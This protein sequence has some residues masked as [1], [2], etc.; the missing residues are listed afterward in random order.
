MIEKY[1]DMIRNPS[2]EARGYTRWWWYGCA[3]TPEGIERQLEIIREAGMGGVE[4]QILY[5]INR[6]DREKGI[7]NI[8][9]FSP[10]FFEILQFT[11]DKC[12][13]LGL[14]MDLT[15]GSSWPFGGPVIPEELAMQCAIPYQ[16]DVHGPCKYQQDLTTRI[17]GDVSAAAMG[18]MEKASMLSETVVNITDR[19]VPKYLFCWPWGTQ[20]EP[21]T[22]PEGDWKLVFF[23]IH[24]YRQMVGKPAP[25]A[26]G[27][28]M[29][30]CSREAADCFFSNMGQPIVDRLGRGSIQSFFCDS[31]ECDGHNWSGVLLKEFRERRGYDL[32]P[33]IYALWGSMGEV[34]PYIRYDYFLTMSELTLE[35][36]FDYFTRWCGQNGSMSRTQAHGTWGDILKAYASAD[37]PEGE[38][39]GEHD[40]LECNTI[41]RRLASSA[42]HLY[43]K[44]IISCE[45]FTWLK[46]PR[47]MET[48]EQMKAAVDAVFLDGM[49]MI[50][51]H[52]FPYSPGDGS[53]GWPFYASSHIC[54]TN[55]WWPFYKHLARYIQ[56][57]SA[58]LRTGKNHAEV[59]IYLPQADIWSDNAL[60]DL[61]LA[62]KLEE[63]I[64]RDTADAINKAGYWFD[65]LNDEALTKLGNIQ[66]GGICVEEN[67]YKVILLIGCTRLPG[68]TACRLIKFVEQGGIL[69]AAEQ[70]PYLGCGF[71]DHER[72]DAEIDNKMQGI[73]KGEGWNCIG[74]GKTVI[75]S[76]RHAGLLGRLRE[77]LRPDVLV[78][79]CDQVGYVH[80][81]D[82]DCHIY[83][84]AN[85]S[86]NAC[87]CELTFKNRNTGFR[88]MGGEDCREYRAAACTKA[89]GAVRVS[90]DYEPFQSFFI[91]FSP[92]LA[93]EDVR[94]RI[95]ADEV[96][97]MEI[98]GWTL[99]VPE[100][101]VEILMEQPAGW[102][103]VEALRYYAGEGIYES[104]FQWNEEISQSGQVFLNL[105][106]VNCAAEVWVNGQHCGDIWKA[107]YHIQ[108]KEALVKG[109]NR[110]RIKAVN[111]LINEAIDPSRPETL[112]PVVIDQW[113]Y[114]G[115]VMNEI[116]KV[117]FFNTR[118]REKISCPQPSGIS[119]RVWLSV[120]PT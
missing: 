113:P 69:I 59:G 110:L 4:I 87:R 72:R 86:S 31:I 33:Y 24:R 78:E 95:P 112:E 34:T 80:R 18:K 5:P 71:V 3:V 55:P 30:H 76:D 68:D 40:K 39:F 14:K 107:P 83:F 67:L 88:I 108:V 1:M 58:M 17:V 106:R 12:K 100:K 117:R 28:V 84:T 16:L 119:G 46:V 66:D 44:N 47:F 92:E 57:V 21:I 48:L 63:H 74:R 60:S 111:T 73:F 25:N 118:E 49:N 81:V 75:A 20:L 23:V 38:T 109:V 115:N 8:P 102:E 116:R 85:I 22:I 19:F 70:R 13:E 120:V 42:G 93:W 103:T 62:M 37:I 91:L 32:A 7:R 35:N 36:F 61:H 101:E 53:R 15:L 97:E 82:G 50:V 65:Y 96:M 6:D 51:N 45:T 90:L 89:D 94:C 9:Y 77:V 105:S 54:N 11:A 104:T 56:R 99:K 79:K 41:H 29:D 52:G 2:D 43:G 27:Y 10:E 26:E 114:F 98:T 64:G